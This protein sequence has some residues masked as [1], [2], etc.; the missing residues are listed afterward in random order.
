MARHQGNAPKRRR[1][2]A[3]KLN[4]VA[5]TAHRAF[6]PL[7]GLWGA[8]LGGGMVMAL[9]TAIFKRMIAGTLLANWSTVIHLLVGLVAAVLLGVV[10]FVVGLVWHKRARGASAEAKP[11]VAK[12]PEMRPIDPARDL[13]SGSLDEPI[14]TMPFATPAWRDFATEP[15]PEIATQPETKPQ[16]ES[17]PERYAAPVA[18]IDTAPAPRELDLAQFAQ[19]PGRNAVWVEGPLPPASPEPARAIRKPDLRAVDAPVVPGTAA[20]DRL[21]AVP[22]SELSLAEMVERFAGGLSEYRAAT[23]ARALSAA[24]LAARDAAL[25]EALKALSSLRGDAP[26]RGAL[27]DQDEPVARRSR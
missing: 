17:K 18:V 2:A 20:L 7:L 6:A 25:A 5:I 13:G 9:P 10:L 1:G 21:R 4:L 26:T 16:P 11:V 22:L 27:T 15:E 8:L 3:P 23:P 19:L 12:A 24:E 14:E